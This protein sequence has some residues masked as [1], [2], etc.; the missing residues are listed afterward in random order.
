MDVERERFDA[1]LKDEMNHPE[2]AKIGLGDV[3]DARLKKSI[4]IL[5]DANKLPRTPTVEE[6][7]TPR[8][9]AAEKLP[10]SRKPTQARSAAKSRRTDLSPLG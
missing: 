3:D 1:T 9:P 8:L 5:V 4:D 6:I 7:F 2:I 10:E